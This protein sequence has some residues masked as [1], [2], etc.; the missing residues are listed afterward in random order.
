MELVDRPATEQLALLNAGD[1]SAT[2]LVDACRARSQLTEP[3]LNALVSV[4]W[5]R[6]AER[7]GALDSDRS[8]HRDAP[9]RGL[10]TAH[11]DLLD[12][13]GV[14]TTYGSQ[15]YASHVPAANSPLVDV[16]AAAGVIVAGKTNTPEF[17]AGSH[18]F[19]SVHGVTRN[20]WDPARSAGGSSGGAAA[21]L[22]CGSLSVADGSDLGGSLRNPASFCGIVGFRPSSGTVPGAPGADPRITMPT[23]GP[24]GRCVSDVGLLLEA[25]TGSSATSHAG[26]APRVLF[27]IGH[28]D[29]PVDPAV[30]SLVEDAALRLE[31][32]GWR[33]ETGD[34]PVAGVDRCFEVLR[35]LAYFLMHPNLRDDPRVKETVRFEIRRGAALGHE[36]IRGALADE[37]RIRATFDRMFDTFDLLLTPTSQVPPFPVGDEWVEEIDGVG[38]GTYTDWMRSCSRLSVPGGPSISL[39]AGFTDE[40]LP[41]GVQLS[42]RR[43]A[44]ADLLATA[45]LAESVLGTSP[46]PPISV[47]AGLDP[48]SLPPGPVA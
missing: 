6:A 39:P 47:L 45:E 41:V 38:L 1:L 28:G 36:E 40:G 20:P 31:A 43:G 26:E 24:M 14:V 18:T 12:T 17:G 16:L 22:S 42:G 11:K 2:E 33:V 7:A 44:D 35:S 32:A 4:D 23:G 46:R 48:D 9:L 25:M 5:D 37:S 3:V 29:L 30:V 15:V 13:A 10:V 8:L 21:A 34:L 27:S 19:N